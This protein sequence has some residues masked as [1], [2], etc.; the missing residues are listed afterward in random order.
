MWIIKQTLRG[1]LKRYII[2]NLRTSPEKV[3]VYLSESSAI[4]PAQT[5]KTLPSLFQPGMS[6]S[7][8]SYLYSNNSILDPP[9]GFLRCLC[10]AV[11]CTGRPAPSAVWH[12]ILTVPGTAH[13]VPDTSQLLRG[14]QK[15]L[16]RTQ[17]HYKVDLRWK[18]APFHWVLCCCFFFTM[19][20]NSF[21][22]ANILYTKSYCFL[23]QLS[24]FS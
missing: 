14:T 1:Y 24:C 6:Q 12:V 21:Q 4:T 23:S 10:I 3:P 7:L 2:K 8:Y 18:D 13:N 11:T 19:H 5:I 20:L 22:I 9:L 17:K 15:L 16:W